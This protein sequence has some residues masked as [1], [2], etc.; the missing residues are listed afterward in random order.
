[1]KKTSLIFLFC[2]SS[3]L[4]AVEVDSILA[5][6]D[7]GNSSAWYHE[8]ILD[9]Y[10]PEKVRA[11]E[12]LVLNAMSNPEISDEAFRLCAKILKPTISEKSIGKLQELLTK[13]VRF[14]PVFDVLIS[15]ESPKADEL[16]IKLLMSKNKSIASHAVYALGI[17]GNSN[18]VQALF[19]LAKSKD[20]NLSNSAVVALG[21]IGGSNAVKALKA[22]AKNKNA[23]KFLVNNA[24]AEVRE[25]FIAKKNTKAAL[26]ISLDED[27]RPALLSLAKLRGIKEMDKLLVA[28][29]DLA[30][31]A[32]RIANDG[33]NYENSVELIGKF[34]RLSDGAKVAAIRSFALSGDKKFLK[35]IASLLSAENNLVTIEA[36]Y[37]CAYIGDETVV[38]KLIELAICK[39]KNVYLPARYSLTFM[40]EPIDK[41]LEEKYAESKDFRLLEI[42]INRGN[43]KYRQELISRFFDENDRK[44]NDIIKVLERQVGYV[45]LPEIAKGFNKAN[46]DVRKDCLRLFIKALSRD[47]DI[48]FR[49]AVFA[50]ALSKANFT[51]SELEILNSRVFTKAKKKK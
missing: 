8:L 28:E 47:R 21:H 41:V 1:M 13:E 6:K 40:S 17:R 37:A 24:L 51:D 9:A 45:C 43:V 38:D 5:F 29:K 14:A 4:N 23:D 3:L 27:F 18:T 33:R 39:D 48:N 34:D 11:T 2:A 15:C 44:R 30:R 32:A 22:L 46:E 12:E 49:K 19:A 26:A 31:N 20:K 25:K 50:E 7:S 36:I 42:L 16:L 10:N 35:Q